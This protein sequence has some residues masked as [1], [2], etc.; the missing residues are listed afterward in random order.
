MPADMVAS[1][2]DAPF[3][4][5]MQGSA[6]GLVYDAQLIGDFTIPATRL[7]TITTPTLVIDGATTPWLTN[8]AEAVGAT[9]VNAQRRTLTGQPHNVAD[10]AIAPLITEFVL[11]GAQ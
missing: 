8:A 7:A 4:E 10:D 3:W 1:M 2:H 11:D 9:I 5:Q 6:Q